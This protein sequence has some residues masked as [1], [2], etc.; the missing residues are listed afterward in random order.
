MKYKDL[1][2]FEPINEVVQ[3]SK[4]NE[5]DYQKNLVKTFVFSKSIK[6]NLIPA[7]V[8]NLDFTNTQETFGIQVV[9]NYGTGKSHLMSLVSLIS[10]DE[11]LLD[12]VKDQDVKKHLSKISGGFK[13][14]RFELGN[15]ESLWEVITY[16]LE[17]FL[18]QNGV[19]FS[20]DSKSPDSFQ[21]KIQLMM[22]EFEAQYPNKGLMIVIDEMLSYLKSRA[23]ATKLNLDLQV[24]QALA[25]ASSKTRFKIMFGVQ[26]LIYQSPEFQFAANMLSKVSDR[27][28]DITI[29][30]EDVAYI[31]KNRL[32]KKN[33][34][35]KK[36]VRN[37]LDKFLKFF[38]DMH[39][40]TEDYVE[41]FPVHPSYFENFEKIK[42]GKS[43]REILK[44]ISRQ[45]EKLMDLDVPVDNPGLL[46]Y[47][48]Y[49]SHIKETTNLM[50]IPDISKVKEITDI[51]EDKIESY[52]TGARQKNK[53]IATR[54][55]NACAIKILQADLSQHHG[56]TIDNLVDDLC[57]TDAL[58]D[59]RNFLIDILQST[60]NSII[61]ATAGQYFDKNPDNGNYYLRIEGGINFDQKIKDYV[62]TMGQGAKDEYFFTFLQNNLP[63][64]DNSYRT[65]FPIWEHT[66]E[67]KSHKTFRNG[68]IF[69]GNP[70]EKS[71][72]QP[73]QHFYMYFMPIF[74]DSKKSKNHEEDE[75]YFVFE[76]L[77]T[78]FRETIS[79]FGAAK[80]L[81]VRAD[82]SQKSNY[83]AIITDL[84]KK[85]RS[86][87][88]EEYLNICKV[89][90]QGKETPLK[91]YP[92]PGSGATKE[93]IFSEV[94]S[95]V[96]ENWFENE[97]PNY[98][99]FSLLNTPVTKDNY[100]RLI[101]SA[102][103]K[104]SS[105]ENSNKDGEAI[106]AGLGLY[107]PGYLDFSHSPFAK[108]LLKKLREKGEGK[109]LNRDE[110]LEHFYGDSWISKDYQIEAELQFLVMA[111]LAALGEIDINISSALTINS[112]NLHE[113]KTLSK[114]DYYS[115]THIAPPK[116]INEAAL[117]ELFIG[118]IGKDYSKHLKNPD[119]YS[120]LVEAANDWSKKAV[121][122][123]AKVRGGLSLKG[124]EIISEDQSAALHRDFSAFSGFCDKVSN[125]NTEPKIKNYPYSVEDTKNI[126]ATRRLVEETIATYDEVKG[127]ES[128]ISYL[129][130]AKQYLTDGSLKERINQLEE[131]L[132]EAFSQGSTTSAL[133][134]EIDLL[135]NEYAKY[136]LD[137][138][139][140]N[141]IK[142][143]DDT[144]KTALLN[145][146]H[147]ALC[148]IL[149][150]AD[151]ISTTQYHDLI[152]DL[153]KLK[154]ADD[155]VN[156]ELI[157]EVPFHDGFNPLEYVIGSPKSIKQI[158]IE[159]E[160][161]LEAWIKQMRE[162][163][164]DPIIK[165]NINVLDEEDA[166][167]L[168]RFKSG[169]LQL[170][171][172]NAI[173]IR[174]AIGTLHKGIEK[175][176]FSP[177]SLKEAFYKPLTPEQALDAF[178]DYLDK[179]CHGK[180]RS[181]VRIF[182]K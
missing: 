131:S 102:I 113:L 37:H 3:F 18:D 45:F 130:Q 175:V 21:K 164:D 155:K 32:L 163:L 71:T 101:K 134:K 68:Y 174:N 67:W 1:I 6:N 107:V 168:D 91:G 119:T 76:D 94:A 127:L 124:I 83:K 95:L 144:L 55:I 122:I 105:P 63:L 72:T 88:E 17:Q 138:Y 151:F 89:E 34:H 161:M 70:N 158:K 139:L 96:L 172:S 166:Q 165:K 5:E 75:V 111:V 66:V 59:D 38:T 176:E 137:A 169:E 64:T 46:T 140:K 182:L 142:E 30:K 179:A 152:K 133:R 81:E 28:I 178:K 143:S 98:P 110:I 177:D 123:D 14:L 60:A 11:S 25:Q 80:A 77:S 69:F 181:K 16:Q 114:P 49:W 157:K 15:T 48:Q 128:E 112:T 23:E 53:A 20:F 149:K 54:I 50:A 79:K 148:D 36:D 121:T 97:S 132:P 82:S 52:F 108:N 92:L 43:Q 136:Y 24:L 150:D 9:G 117:K 78:E 12:Y 100:E 84:E 103:A 65:G 85:A 126:I 116:G 47:E 41:L 10:E 35:Q 135:K 156:L 27:Y 39:A 29:R 61:S 90:Y 159:L 86:L 99:K 129:L 87:F 153:Q 33:E 141:R 8:Q 62:G 104:I 171:K 13:V 40:K 147:K 2:D 162:T 57:Y 51:T 42:I 31:V 180:E 22:A 56:T 115:F 4:T 120:K 106:L 167:L 19:D 160:E 154:K 74:D 26:E 170:D 118:L 109:V 58:A 145:S 125:Y 173:K 73:H 93:Q 44:T 146:D 7:I